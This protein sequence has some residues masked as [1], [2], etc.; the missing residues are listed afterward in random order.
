MKNFLISLIT[1]T[2]VANPVLACN[3]SEDVSKNSD[4]SYN[5]TKE[6]HIKVGEVVET[7]EIQKK[8]IEN[9]NQIIDHKDNVIDLHRK[10]VKNWKETSKEL[11]EH[12]NMLQATKGADDWVWFG[13][14][15]LATSAAVYGA[16]HLD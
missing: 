12:V 6:C 10:R 2:F 9:F 4:G 13:L 14:G 7:N 5:Y 15:V 16:G 8:Q 1:I 3:W 11:E